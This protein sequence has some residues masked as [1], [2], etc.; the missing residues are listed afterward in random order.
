MTRKSRREL[1]RDLADLDDTGRTDL[2][3]IQD[4]LEFL[5]DAHDEQQ[6]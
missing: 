1:T 6:Q 4:Q 2:E 3:E 5:N